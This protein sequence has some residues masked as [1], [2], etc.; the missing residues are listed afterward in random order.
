MHDIESARVTRGQLS[1]FDCPT[2]AEVL[3][4]HGVGLEVARRMFYD[5]HLTFEPEQ[6]RKLQP[7]AEAELDFLCGLAALVGTRHLPGLLAPLES[8]FAYRL[9]RL[10]FD[11]RAR[12][13]HLRPTYNP[14]PA[15]ELDMAG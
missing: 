2:V 5:G 10:G 1:L 7:A 8:P 11:F 13:W 9:E 4:R 15:H 12:C 3:Q 6:R 14:S